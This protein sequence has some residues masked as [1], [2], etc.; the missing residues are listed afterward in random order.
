[1]R[2]K[3]KHLKWAISAI[4]HIRYVGL[5]YIKHNKAALCLPHVNKWLH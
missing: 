5:G 2:E 1:M 3:K 4:K